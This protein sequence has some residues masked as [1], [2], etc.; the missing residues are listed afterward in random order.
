MYVVYVV[1]HTVLHR[2]SHT[3]YWLDIRPVPSLIVT[4]LN[5]NDGNDNNSN[6]NNND[7]DDND[8]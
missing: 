1:S 2:G 5:N 4:I 6:D 3:D 7:A 8:S